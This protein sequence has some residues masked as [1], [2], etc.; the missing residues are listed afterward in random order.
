M[1]IHNPTAFM[2]GIWD[3]GFLNQCFFPTTIKVT[4]I[5]GFVERNG[6]F[7][8]IET[9]QPNVAILTGQKRMFDAFVA[10]GNACLII[11]GKQK[12]PPYR[13]LYM[14]PFGDNEMLGASEVHIQMFVQLW[15]VTVNQGTN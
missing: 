10:A 2:E 7:L 12:Q 5:D 3:W 15:F 14:T 1:T 13:L 9:K 6:K 8:M 4:D 11:W